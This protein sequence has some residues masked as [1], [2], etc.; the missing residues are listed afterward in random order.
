MQITS[1]TPSSSQNTF[2]T[3]EGHLGRGYLAT[4]FTTATPLAYVLAMFISSRTPN[5]MGYVRLARRVIPNTRSSS[6]GPSSQ[7][8][9]AVY[10]WPNFIQLAVIL[11]VSGSTDAIFAT[12]TLL[13][14]AVV[15]DVDVDDDEEEDD[16]D[17]EHEQE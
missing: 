6:Q 15:S 4:S 14:S 2:C 11:S 5:V 16:D 7:L 3:T 13:L 8:H 9:D 10:L 12:S 17:D 1:L